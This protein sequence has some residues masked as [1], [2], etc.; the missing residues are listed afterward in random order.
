MSVEGFRPGL[1][2]GGT[3]HSFLVTIAGVRRPGARGVSDAF[4][5]VIDLIASVGGVGARAPAVDDTAGDAI[6]LSFWIRL[7][8]PIGLELG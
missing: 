4:G 7:V 6:S 2:R 8:V 5:R 1:R 3:T